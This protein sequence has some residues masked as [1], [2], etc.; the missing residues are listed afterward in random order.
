M[1]KVGSDTGMVGLVEEA[2]KQE[3]R[4]AEL[5]PNVL[6]PTTWTENGTAPDTITGTNSVNDDPSQGVAFERSHCKFPYRTTYKG[7]DFDPDVETS[8]TCEKT[9]DWQECVPGTLPR[10]C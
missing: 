3:N 8:W 4:Q 10:L 7:S 5:L 6:Y 1:R 2:W 9:K